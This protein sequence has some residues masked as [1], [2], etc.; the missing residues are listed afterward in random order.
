MAHRTAHYRAQIGSVR[1]CRGAVRLRFVVSV[2]SGEL[3][4]YRSTRGAARVGRGLRL[5]PPGF[6]L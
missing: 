2:S 4:H 1:G 5:D 6:A 3:R